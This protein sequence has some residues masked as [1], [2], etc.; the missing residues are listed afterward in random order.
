MVSLATA[1]GLGWWI[2]MDLQSGV[3]GCP[4]IA[5]AHSY[6]PLSPERLNLLLR[7]VEL[8]SLGDF[9]R[10]FTYYSVHSAGDSAELS[11][12]QELLRDEGLSQSEKGSVRCDL[13]VYW[14]HDSWTPR[15]QGCQVVNGSVN[16]QILVI[17][18]R[19]VNKS[20]HFFQ[21]PPSGRVLSA[22]IWGQYIACSS[23]T[24]NL[25][26]LDKQMFIGLCPV[27]NLV[28]TQGRCWSCVGESTIQSLSSLSE[29]DR[30][31]ANF[32]I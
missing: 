30:L 17:L 20:Q 14:G 10:A 24:H 2:R 5:K 29:K 12:L 7:Q 8:S 16:M 11:E 15:S 18:L 1:I 19:R 23:H 32:I 13:C 22:L 27:Q 4:P 28:L 3:C 9:I 26:F 6:T 25:A 31:P 21:H